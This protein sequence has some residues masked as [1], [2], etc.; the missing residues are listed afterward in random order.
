MTQKPSHDS[1]HELLALLYVERGRISDYAYRPEANFKWIEQEV[2]ETTNFV[3]CALFTAQVLCMVF[4][5]FVLGG[6]QQGEGRDN[7]L[8]AGWAIPLAGATIGLC[9]KRLLGR[10]FLGAKDLSVLRDNYERMCLTPLFETAD[11]SLDRQERDRAA[12]RTAALRGV[13]SALAS[14]DNWW[15]RFLLRGFHKLSCYVVV[16]HRFLWWWTLFVGIGAVLNSNTGKAQIQFSEMMADV[17]RAVLIALVA[18]V[19]TNIIR[20]LLVL[21]G[22]YASTAGS[23][24]DIDGALLRHARTLDDTVRKIKTSVFSVRAASSIQS[25]GSVLQGFRDRLEK[26]T[27]S[28]SADLEK[29]YFEHY[30][31]ALATNASRLL[32]VYDDWPSAHRLFGAATMTSFIEEQR[33]EDSRYLVRF[34]TLAKVAE[35]VCRAVDKLAQSAN[36]GGKFEIFALVAMPPQRFLNKGQLDE[37]A[38]PGRYKCGHQNF[39]DYLEYFA[40]RAQCSKG[41]THN[42]NDHLH[43]DTYRFFLSITP[44][45]GESSLRKYR[46]DNRDPG[47]IREMRAGERHKEFVSRM[48]TAELTELTSATVREQ[49]AYTVDVEERVPVSKGKEVAHKEHRSLAQRERLHGAQEQWRYRIR[50]SDG[51]GETLG[52]VLGRRYHKAG[53]CRVL[54]LHDWEAIEWLQDRRTGKPKDYFAVACDG[55]WVFCLRSLFDSDLDVADVEICRPE[56]EASPERNEKWNELQRDLNLLFHRD[57]TPG[58]GSHHEIESYGTTK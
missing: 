31:E 18:N 36:G 53:Y 22:Q 6:A 19:A 56:P 24:R 7:W 2:N 15:R 54:E 35:E 9:G 3:N 10:Y 34:S 46:K 11:F 30:T 1:N 57:G 51:S 50:H 21:R 48:L 32:Q 23:V 58:I 4:S 5:L 26:T 25:L 17:M 8:R 37:G 38:G 55:N 13:V 29:S 20:E 44:E 45:G 12:A 40:D 33:P 47:F 49:L 14:G 42:E 52:A 39:E 16:G 43:V 28:D 27:D 41:S